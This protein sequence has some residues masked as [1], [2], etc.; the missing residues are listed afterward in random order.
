MPEANTLN[1]KED[2][3]QDQTNI[4]EPH[5]MSQGNTES[6]EDD[7]EEEEEEE[8]VEEKSNGS[9]SE[10]EAIA[11]ATKAADES[12][13]PSQSLM[14]S[15]SPYPLIRSVDGISLKKYNPDPSRFS[16]KDV[17]VPLRGKLNVPIHV[18]VSGSIVDYTV[19]SKDFDIGFG[20]VAEREEGVTVVKERQRQ[21][22][23]VEAITGRFLVGSVPCA[24]IFTFDNEYSW[25]RE[26]K[27]TYKIKVTPPSFENICSGRRIRAKSA[28]AVV[29]K[30]KESAE[31]RLESVSSKHSTLVQ[32]I[33]RLEMELKE[34]KKSLGVFEKEVSWLK[35]RVQLREV[36]EDLLTRR[37]T[38]GWE[39]ED[40][41][42]GEEHGG[43]GSN[44]DEVERVEI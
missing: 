35:D 7:A 10:T 29:A 23:H 40:I 42:V 18:T 5:I 22:A 3:P 30:D 44:V 26:K 9:D 43:S 24:L 21:N 27:I 15:S 17:I 33:E 12:Y 39:D 1:S 28:L 13:V 20:V 19:E 8:Q 2:A 4:K 11:L 6:E 41:V 16:A 38:E 32:D 37:L 31:T 25:F 14:S 36:Q 34:K